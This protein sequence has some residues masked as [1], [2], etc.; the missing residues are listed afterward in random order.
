[1]L[2]CHQYL[3]FYIKTAQPKKVLK[4]PIYKNDLGANLKINKMG[5]SAMRPNNL[6]PAENHDFKIRMDSSFGPHCTVQN[7]K[8]KI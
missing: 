5:F 3:I 4:L 8:L 1:M 6:S 7:F 2:R